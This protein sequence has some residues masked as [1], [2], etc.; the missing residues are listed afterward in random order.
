M[1]EKLTV[2]MKRVEDVYSDH[3][4]Y[5]WGMD[6]PLVHPRRSY[7]PSRDFAQNEQR[8]ATMSDS[9]SLMAEVALRV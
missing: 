9:D 8:Q 7:R 2:Q 3:G 6:S 4:D 5:H 1:D